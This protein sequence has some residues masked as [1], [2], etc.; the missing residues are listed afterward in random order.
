[1]STTEGTPATERGLGAAEDSRIRHSLG[2]LAFT[3]VWICLGVAILVF[4]VV[5]DVPLRYQLAPLVLSVVVLGLPHG[6]V[7]HLAVSRARGDI[8][9]WRRMG[10]IGGLYLVVGGVYAVVWYVAPAAAFAGFILLTW[11]HWGQGDLYALVALTDATHLQE[12][13]RKLLTAATRGALPMVV[14]LVAFPEDYRAVAE[15]LTGLFA[16]GAVD[17]LSVAFTP[18]GRAGA[19]AVVA[20]LVGTTV[21]TGYH[22]VHSTAGRR[23]WA[24]DAGETV[25][26][27]VF[28]LT[29]PPIFAI[30]L[31]FC[32][33]HALRHVL[34]LVLVDGR[35]VAAVRDGKPTDAAVR[36]ARDAAP[37]TGASIA[38]LAAF[39]WLVPNRPD[40]GIEWIGLY[41]VFIAVLTLPHVVV[42]SWMDRIEGVW[43]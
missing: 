29:V 43:S 18:T 27:V 13:W 8:P 14:P 7:D 11:A 35:S 30:G 4:L 9:T 20:L 25:L 24:V 23:A 5:P 37:L 16:P 32:V 41:L 28:F 38:L 33:W 42:V 34:R 6:A 19:A 22:A 3:P 31:Y 21:A 26:L 1:M 40:A 39:Y 15:A 10:V 36:F 12:R 2:A 17:A